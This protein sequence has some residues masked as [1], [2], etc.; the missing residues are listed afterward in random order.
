MWKETET[1]KIG[2]WR[3]WPVSEVNSKPANLFKTKGNLAAEVAA[4]RVRK[5][6]LAEG[7]QPGS[8]RL[9]RAEIPKAFRH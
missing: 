7:K 3:L 2:F 5:G 6:V 9:Y 4:I 1:E 8:N